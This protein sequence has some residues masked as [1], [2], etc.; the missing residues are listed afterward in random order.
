M[1]RTFAA[2]TLAALALATAGGAN[3]QDLDGRQLYV[4]TCAGCHGASG[5]G[6]Y[7]PPLTS[8][9][10]LADASAL[11]TQILFGR[12][13]MPPMGGALDDAELAAVANFLRTVFNDYEGDVDAGL[14]AGLR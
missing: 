11:V 13:N 9:A 4:D 2:A 1:T 7:G 6:S 8:N 5:E 3:A 14:V 10:F 12:E